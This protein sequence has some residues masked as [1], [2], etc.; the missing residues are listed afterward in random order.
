MTYHIHQEWNFS[1]LILL[2]EHTE[3]KNMLVT[4]YIYGIVCA[5]VALCVHVWHCVCM[6][7]IVC[8]C[9]QTNDFSFVD[10]FVVRNHCLLKLP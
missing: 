3:D 6:C 8:A 4:V 10:V 1:Y 7:G 5:C 2:P 9:V